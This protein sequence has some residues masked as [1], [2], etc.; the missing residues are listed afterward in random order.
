MPRIKSYLI[1]HT[2]SYFKPSLLTGSKLLLNTYSY[3]QIQGNTHA[4]TQYTYKCLHA[5]CALIFSYWN[6]VKGNGPTIL[7]SY[8]MIYCTVISKFPKEFPQ[9]LFKITNTLIWAR[10]ETCNCPFQDILRMANSAYSL[11]TTTNF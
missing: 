2:K 6:F 9:K 10:L 4:Q 5:T 3:A 7:E 11:L 8:F 1:F